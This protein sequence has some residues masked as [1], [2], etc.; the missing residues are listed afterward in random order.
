MLSIKWIAFV[1][2]GVGLS[3]PSLQRWCVDEKLITTAKIV[4]MLYSEYV[5][6][7]LSVW[8]CWPN[9]FLCSSSVFFFGQWQVLERLPKVN[10]QSRVGRGYVNVAETFF[11]QRPFKRLQLSLC[12]AAPSPNKQ[13]GDRVPFLCIFF[14]FF[15]KC[16]NLACDHSRLPSKQIC[17]WNSLQCNREISEHLKYVRNSYCL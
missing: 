10:Q 15:Q 1:H 7:Y 6:Y 12:T 4:K 9:L 13:I 16:C 17:I 3:K 11:P 2:V 5:D 14:F 8:H